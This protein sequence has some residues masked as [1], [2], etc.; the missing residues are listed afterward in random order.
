MQIS[1]QP[2]NYQ[3]NFRQVNLVQVPKKVFQNPERLKECSV[4]F[5]KALDKASGTE[6]CLGRFVENLIALFGFGSKKVSK[7]YSQLE[8]QS[9]TICKPLVDKY[10]YSMQ[11]L[12]QNTGTKLANAIDKDMHSFYVLTGEHKDKACDKVKM[13]AWVNEVLRY[14]KEGAVKHSGDEAM[15]KLYAYAKIGDDLDQK[16]NQIIEG[17]DIHKFKVENLDELK[18]IVDKLGI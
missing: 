2:R 11:W 15:T 9:Y 18:G 12:G 10:G 1:N 5:S 7:M 16:F 13:S 3:P 6:F 17:S 8:H 14:S 4:L